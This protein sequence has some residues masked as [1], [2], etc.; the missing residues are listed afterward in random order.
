ML[1][2]TLQKRTVFWRVDQSALA[3]PKTAFFKGIFR[4]PF[5]EGI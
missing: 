3:P 4:Y 5:L 1:Y 2:D